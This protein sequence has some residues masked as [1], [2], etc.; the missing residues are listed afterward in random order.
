MNR[1]YSFDPLVDEKS[2]IVILGT[3]PGEK[4]LEEKCYYGNYKNHFWDI[5]YRVLQPDFDFFELAKT[6]SKSEK[7]QLLLDNGIGLWD[8]I[9]SC[10]RTGSSDNKIKNEIL[11][12]L[13][14]FFQRHR[15]IKTVLFNGGKAQKYF[16]KKHSGIEFSNI[17]FHQLNSTSTLNPNN[18]FQI[19]NEWKRKIK[20]LA[21]NK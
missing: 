21:N 3:I 7:Y 12:D 19:M 17:E 4:S 5:M 2:E 8:V 9:E 6:R 14:P 20:T 10:E 13:T 16:F 1:I 11:N 15:N 18:T